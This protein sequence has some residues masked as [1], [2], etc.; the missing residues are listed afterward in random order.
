MSDQILRHIQGAD[1]VRDDASQGSL[2][3]GPDAQRIQAGGSDIE[4]PLKAVQRMK[5]IVLVASGALHGC[6]KHGF[7]MT[8]EK[9]LQ[10]FKELAMTTESVSYTHLRAHETRHD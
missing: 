6:E 1:L 5:P 7:G 2:A 3:V 8:I 4:R 10:D 9:P